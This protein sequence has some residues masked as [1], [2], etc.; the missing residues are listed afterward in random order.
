MSVI[1]RI[2]QQRQSY[3]GKAKIATKWQ[4]FKKSWPGRDRVCVGYFKEIL[5]KQTR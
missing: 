1:L 5:D 2:R 4:R 3:L